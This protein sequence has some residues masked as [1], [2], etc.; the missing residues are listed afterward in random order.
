MIKILNALVKMQ[1]LDDI[2]TEKEVLK[3]R[4]PLKLE[5]LEKNVNT[6]QTEVDNIKKS[7][8]KNVKERDKLEL[9]VKG[10]LE[11]IEKYQNQLPLIKTNKEY[12]ALN[13]EIEFLKKKNSSLDDKII[14][15][16]DEEQVVRHQLAEKK[17]K[18]E[19]AEK[20]LEDKVDFLRKQVLIVEKEIEQTKEKRKEIAKK[21]PVQVIKRY[22]NLIIHKN[23][24]AVV[25]VNKSK[26]CG[27]CGFSIRPQLLIDINLKDSIVS[28]ESCGRMIIDKEIED[29]I[30]KEENK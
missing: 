11:N 16:M 23:R 2:I 24:K 12:K 15:E 22:A 19:T 10:N 1:H 14:K 30:Q 21:L 25:F 29:K 13:D 7:L 5:E 9:E 20:E 26:G 4:I 28:C 18:L 3:K 8:D 27:G 17:T 6:A